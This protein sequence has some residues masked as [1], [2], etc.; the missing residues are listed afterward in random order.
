MTV[1]YRGPVMNIV[2]GVPP[3]YEKIKE[4]F[5]DADYDKGTLFTYGDTCYAKDITEDLCVHEAVHV[6]QQKA[7]GVEK[8][9]DRYYVDAEFRLSQEGEAY[10]EQWKWILKNVKD[11]NK[12][13]NLLIHIIKALSGPLYNGL[14]SFDE[15]KNIILYGNIPS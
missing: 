4:Y 6:K 13:S 2:H 8:W 10:H 3:N 7:M 1:V 11:R 15:A 12:R 9:W 14:V 5:P